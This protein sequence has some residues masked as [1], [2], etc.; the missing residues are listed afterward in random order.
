MQKLLVSL[1]KDGDV[2]LRP[3][4]SPEENPTKKNNNTTF[5]DPEEF[6]AAIG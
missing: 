4:K 5:Q 2:M 3:A 6:I 1:K